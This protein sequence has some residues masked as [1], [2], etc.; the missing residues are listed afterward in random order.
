MPETSAALV[1]HSSKPAP[2]SRILA[3]VQSFF[4]W[5]VE[6]VDLYSINY[7]HFGARKVCACSAHPSWCIRD[8]QQ[9][10]LLTCCR[11]LYC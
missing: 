4:S 1:K 7:L 2:R 8:G 10:L 5:H 9:R 11:Y 6:D 3:V